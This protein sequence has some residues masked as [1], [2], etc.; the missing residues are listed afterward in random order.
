MYLWLVFLHVLAGFAYMMAHGAAA[1]VAFRL[2]RETSRE[3]AAALLDLSAQAFTLM[4]GALL[5]TLLAGIALGFLGHWWGKIWIWLVL[6]LTVGKLAAMFVMGASRFT[7][8]RKLVGLPYFD[9]KQR[10]AQPPAGADEIAARLAAV[11]P[12]PLAII[13]FGGLAVML[14]LMILK[15][16]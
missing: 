13:G 14:W 16:F 6:L 2:R 10:P 12:L 11:N 5:V 1:N 9:G 15:P 4:Y 7:Q 3:R 8:L